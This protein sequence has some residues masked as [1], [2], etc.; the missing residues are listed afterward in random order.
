LKKRHARA[1]LS[2]NAIAAEASPAALAVAATFRTFD[3]QLSD[4]EIAHIAR[5]IDAL[6]ALGAGLNPK[7][8][9]LRNADDLIVRFTVDASL[10]A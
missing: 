8:R 10:D 1:T 9:P 4:D 6:R 5:E 2:G 7:R 3:P